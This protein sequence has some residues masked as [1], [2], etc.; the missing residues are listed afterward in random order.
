MK[1]QVRGADVREAEAWVGWCCSYCAAP[2]EVRAHGLFCRPEGRFFA[3]LDGV[4]RLLPEERRRELLPTVELL[5]RTRRDA[6]WRAEPG[7]PEV[8]PGHP[9]GEVWRRRARALREGFALAAERIDRGPWNVLE[10]GGGCGWAAARFLAAGHRVA[11]VDVNLDRADGLLATDRVTGGAALPRAEAELEAL[12]VEPRRFDVV[13]TPC[14]LHQGARL[15][16]A[17]VELRRVTRRGGILLVLDSPVFRRREDGEAA[18]ARVM[19]EQE[20]RYRVCL[21]RESQPGYL[22]LGELP[23]LF[24]RAGWTAEVHGWP[25]RLRE[26]AG[27]AWQALRHGRRGPRFPVLV[28]RRDG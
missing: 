26:W 27:D 18:V 11:A 23:S 1:D 22:V 9:H 5:Q 3:D 17:L 13:V 24:A 28:A 12:P 25:D 10:V 8:P 6:G 15:S 20:R 16:R 21:P 19:R 2:L 7:L 4:H 14:S